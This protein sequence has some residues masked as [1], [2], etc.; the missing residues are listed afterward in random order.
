M[1]VYSGK[2]YWNEFNNWDEALFQDANRPRDDDKFKIRPWLQSDKWKW[3]SVN[4]D[5]DVASMFTWY[6]FRQV[7]NT[8]NLDPAKYDFY[9][10]RLK[11][12]FSNSDLEVFDW[13]RQRTKTWTSDEIRG[14]LQEAQSTWNPKTRIIDGDIEILESGMYSISCFAQFLRPLGH[15]RTTMAAMWVG[16]VQLIDWTYKVIWSTMSRSCT[17]MDEILYLQA[18]YIEKGTRIAPCAC[19]WYW[20]VLVVGWMLATRIW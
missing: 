18:Q 6:W 12:S 2:Q 15:L 1:I 14:Y 4:K 17:D 19:E 8:A 20:T 9:R 10:I 3:R 7:S 5:L 11:E 13:Y 16:L